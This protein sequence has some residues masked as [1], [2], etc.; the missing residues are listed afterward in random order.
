M[1]S[2]LSLLL[3]AAA[4]ALAHA[5]ILVAELS[6][7]VSQHRNEG[8][9]V[10][11]LATINSPHDVFVDNNG[12]VLIGSLDLG[13]AF[14]LTSLGQGPQYLFGDGTGRSQTGIVQDANGFIYTSDFQRNRLYKWTPSGA[15][16]ATFGQNTPGADHIAIRGDILYV[17][18]FF[19]NAVYAYRL[20][21][22]SLE[23]A[24]EV[25]LAGPTG[26]CFDQNG[27]LYVCGFNNG[28]I[29]RFTPDFINGFDV[30]FNVASPHGMKIGPDGYLYVCEQ[31]RGKI[32]KIAPDGSSM[33]T[34][35]SGLGLPTDVCFGTPR[36]REKPLPI[37][38][39]TIN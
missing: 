14:K 39:S 7:K 6:G 23:R 4:A 31:G 32:L 36:L 17:T 26:I 37:G 2:T 25:Q 20:S 13:K 5:D 29:R 38:N 11:N 35:I 19:N 24:F 34:H 9:F 22:L 27:W 1:K 18:A 10:R 28:R 15:L 16:V 33:T 12:A 8:T 21:D 3:L 30:A